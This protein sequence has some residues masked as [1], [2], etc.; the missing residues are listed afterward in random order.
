MLR[1]LYDILPL[2]QDKRPAIISIQYKH[3]SGKISPTLE[4]YLPTKFELPDTRDRF[5]SPR[6]IGLVAQVCISIKSLITGF[7]T[8]TPD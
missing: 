5:I 2:I 6:F 3:S 7:V 8:A 1:Q 4:K